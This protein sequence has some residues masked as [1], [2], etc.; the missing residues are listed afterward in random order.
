MSS[1]L[2]LLLLPLLPLLRPLLIFLL[3]MAEQSG[4]IFYGGVCEQSVNV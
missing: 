3:S 4:A 1:C 2:L